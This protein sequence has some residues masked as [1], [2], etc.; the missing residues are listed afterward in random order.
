MGFFNEG[1][2]LLTTGARADVHG[3]VPPTFWG[4]TW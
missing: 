2:V 4:L 3:N 1:I